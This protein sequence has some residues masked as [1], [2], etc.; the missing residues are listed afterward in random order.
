MKEKD[1]VILV[2]DCLLVDFAY[3]RHSVQSE[4]FRSLVTKYDVTEDSRVKR[5]IDKIVDKLFAL[6]EVNH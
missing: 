2:F 3:L 4:E 5:T 1:M 6:N